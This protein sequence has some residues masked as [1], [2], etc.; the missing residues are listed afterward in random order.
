MAALIPKQ[1]FFCIGAQKAGTTTLANILSQHPDIYIPSVKETKFFLFPEEY[2][3]GLNYY[4]STF[5]ADYNG[6]KVVGELDPDYM[7]VPETANRIADTLGKD[8]R[9]IVVLRNPAT[10]AYSHY[11]MSKKKGIE[12]LEFEAALVA[13]ATRDKSIKYFKTIAYIERGKYGS[14]LTAYLNVFPANQFLFLEFEKD[15]VQQLDETLQRIQTF[16]NVQVVQLDSS[17][18]SNEAAEAVND[19][20]RDMVRR[21]N[22]VKSLMKKLIPFKS[23]RRK[24]RKYLIDKNLQASTAIGLD[25]ATI[26]RI[27]EQYFKEEILST[28]KLT[29]L[30]LT[31]WLP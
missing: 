24:A 21:P 16:L 19:G 31:D 30:S 6:Q 25:K 18:R 22:F 26:Q 4:N 23:M 20:I 12:S 29:G 3:K 2:S 13:E 5:Y 11:L 15:I 1:N 27:N 14:Q 8:I 17:I 28:R 9:F 7:L 10:R